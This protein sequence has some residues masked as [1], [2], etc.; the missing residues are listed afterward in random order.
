MWIKDYKLGECRSRATQSAVA[1]IAITKRYSNRHKSRS[2]FSSCSTVAY[3]TFLARVLRIAQ[4]GHLYNFTSHY[5]FLLF[6]ARL[7]GPTRPLFVHKRVLLFPHLVEHLVHLSYF[8]ARHPGKSTISGVF[9]VKIFLK[10]LV[11]V[12]DR[13]PGH[14]CGMWGFRLT[15]TATFSKVWRTLL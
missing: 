14:F 11:S 9:L 10:A 13:L 15:P 7:L 6:H 4:Q 8:T 2:T 3:L 1:L 12:S 5:L